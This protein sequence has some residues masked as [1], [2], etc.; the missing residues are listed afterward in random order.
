MFNSAKSD[1]DK[2]RKTTYYT[3]PGPSRQILTFYY[4]FLFAPSSAS[5]PRLFLLFFKNVFFSIV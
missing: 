3:D 1:R 2:S 5:F 4:Q